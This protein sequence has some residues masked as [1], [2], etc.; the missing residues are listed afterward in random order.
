MKKITLLTA[1]SFFCAVTMQAQNTFPASG[2]VGIGTTTPSTTL[3]ING[4]KA[5]NTINSNA[6]IFKLMRP[7]SPG[8]KWENIAQFDLGSYSGSTNATSRL[9]LSLNDGGGIATSKI[10]TWQANG[11]IGI[12]TTSP[13]SLLHIASPSL[14]RTLLESTNGSGGQASIDLKAGNFQYWRLIGQGSTNGGRFDIHNQTLNRAAFSILP[15]NNIGIGTTT[16]TAK[17]D[18]TGTFKLN[19]GSQGVGKVLTSDADGNASWQKLATPDWASL[20]NANSGNIGIGTTTPTAK[21]DVSGTFKLNDGSQGIGKVLTS[22]AD[23]N[24]SWQKLATPNW[25][26]LF[27]A[28]SGNIGI[29]TTTPTAKL[30][31]TGTFKLYDGSQ[32]TGKVLT[33]DANGNAS[34]QNLATPDWAS[35]FN[36]NSG[37]IGIGTTTPTAKLDVTGTF[38]LNDGSQGVGKVLTSDASGNASWQNQTA[39]NGGWSTTNNNLSNTNS[40][41][42]GIGTSNPVAK[43]TVQGNILASS[44]KVAVPSSANW[45]DYVFAKE[46]QLQPLEEVEA[47][48]KK[49]QHLPNVPSAAEMVKEGNDL[50]KTDA[51]LLEKIEE[52]TL[53]VIEMKKENVLMKKENLELKKEMELLKN[54]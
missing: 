41:N 42:I 40:G 24:A 14:A 49:N 17:L 54:K 36:A 25:A 32:G 28:D 29:G 1:L 4:I 50:G 7:Q 2:N 15:N 27:N 19:D 13:T 37:N 33:S 23:G 30:D 34:W 53:Y 26:S 22:D 48:I 46:Y 20:F 31:V 3:Q 16:P 52:L 6:A 51:K 47:F 5:T 12:G 44:I 8:V 18:V 35:L 9:D 38:K 39:N 11:N 10:M 43:L 45:S 21:L